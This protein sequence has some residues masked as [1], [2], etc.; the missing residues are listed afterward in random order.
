VVAILKYP[1][2]KIEAYN[3]LMY[4]FPG[5]VIDTIHYTSGSYSYTQDYLN[6]RS[7][8]RIMDVTNV[9]IRVIRT[10]FIAASHSVILAGYY[11]SR[12]TF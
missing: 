9:T 11:D 3:V 5:S 1:N 10:T 7:F 6:T 2:P 12:T 8:N 4:Q